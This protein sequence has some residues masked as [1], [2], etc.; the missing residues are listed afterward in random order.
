MLGT[1]L[2]A[3]LGAGCKEPGAPTPITVT[4]VSPARDWLRGKAGVTITGTNFLD[5]TSVTIG[6]SEL[7][8]RTV[9][10]STEITGTAPAST[11]AG[12]KDVVVTSS[13][14]GSGTCS[15]CF[16]YLSALT[17]AAVSAGG[18]SCGITTDGRAYCW[19]PN[20][21]GGLGNGTITPYAGSTVPVAVAGGLTLQ[22][23]SVRRHV[24]AVATSGAAWCWGL[25][26]KGQIGDG[27]I[28]NQG[29]PT[30]VQGG[31]R[32]AQV[33]AGWDLT[34]G[35]TVGGAAYCWGWNQFGQLGDGTEIDRTSPVAVVGGLGFTEVSAG[36][37]HTC[38]VTTEGAAYCWGLN[39]E[40]EFGNVGCPLTTTGPCAVSGGLTFN[41]VSVGVS[42]HTC[43]VTTDGAAYCWGLNTSGQLGI[44]TAHGSAAP[45]AV[46]GGLTFL[47]VSTGLDFTCGITT[48]HKA[49][50]WGDNYAGE[51][52][53]STITGPETCY[54]GA[55]IACSTTPV[56]VAGELTF[57]MVS[58]GL[59]HACGITTE[60]AA[61]CWGRNDEGELGDGTTTSSSI[62][63]K[64]TGSR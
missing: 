8:D 7:V 47:T 36:Q 39:N 30:A 55:W 10:S 27:T 43:G 25:N 40:G 32:F 34:C 2:G 4:G 42:H 15:G 22:S 50:C 56:A 58:A 11:S 52:G 45:I 35:V 5:V 6:G 60:G 13:S 28:E 24:C 33:S 14:H 19:G 48:G 16:T 53:D 49:Y 37:Y 23:V 61:Y 3:L 44:G 1:V 62:P 9:V 64:V 63:V 18:D 54:A 38:G 31:L 21:W 46:V 29:H 59:G 57:T 12:A 20:G 51:L 26:E 17:F 41:V